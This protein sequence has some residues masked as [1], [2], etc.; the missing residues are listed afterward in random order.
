MTTIYKYELDTTDKQTVTIQ[1]DAEILAVQ[2][3]FEIPCIWAMIDT[4]NDM[5]EIT[6]EI[7]GTGHK[8]PVDMGVVRQ[9]LGTYQIQG[10]SQI[11]HVFK[12]LN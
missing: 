5:E 1:K 4:E 8:I 6:I 10:G 2:A 9:H 11:Y 7:F 3:Q 12:R